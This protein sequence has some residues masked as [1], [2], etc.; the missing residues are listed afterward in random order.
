MV[1]LVTTTEVEWD[2]TQRNWMLALAAWRASRCPGCGGD[3]AETTNP[4]NQN[5]YL[6]EALRC[7][8]CTALHMSAAEWADERASM[9]VLHQ[10]HLQTA[11]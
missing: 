8:R 5:R 3:L 10:V 1:K 4:D 11:N 7:H 2:D 9:A 6:T